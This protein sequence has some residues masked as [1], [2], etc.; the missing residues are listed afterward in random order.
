MF[1]YYDWKDDPYSPNSTES[2]FGTVSNALYP[3]PGYRAALALQQSLGN[4]TFIERLDSRST[5][6]NE[7]VFVL[8]FDGAR[9]PGARAYAAWTSMP[10][11]AVPQDARTKCVNVTS[12]DL[13][14]CIAAGCCFDETVPDESARCFEGTALPVSFDTGDPNPGRCFDVVDVFGYSRGPACAIDGTLSFNVS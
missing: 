13:D 6:A 5:A 3:K 8:R 4:G 9:T 2:H 14:E 11:C 1:S 12:A 7:T 10:T